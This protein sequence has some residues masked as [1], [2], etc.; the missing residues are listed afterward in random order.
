MEAEQNSE[1]REVVIRIRDLWVSFGERQVLR[2]A[3]LDIYRGETLVILGSSGSGKS[4]LLRTIIGACRPERGSVHVLGKDFHSL[5]EKGRAEILGRFGVLFQGGALYTSMTVGDNVALPLREHTRLDEEII[6]IIVKM[7]LE[8]VGMRHAEDLRP[9]ELSGG[10][11]KRAALARAIALDP[12]IIFY[13]EPTTGLDPVMAGTVNSLIERFAGRMG[14]TSVVVTQDMACAFRVA[15]RTAL[16]NEGRIW[17]TGS[18]EEL[19][20]SDDPYV[21]RFVRGEAEESTA[22]RGSL[23]SL[24][25]ELREVSGLSERA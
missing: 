10:M 22:L 17:F 2:G 21:R 7:K 5:D 25:E 12:E 14:V 15:T 16:V 8:L 20:S 19:R 13:D 6:R 23:R 18:P 1:A 4:T 9:A 11:Q 3:D 24:A